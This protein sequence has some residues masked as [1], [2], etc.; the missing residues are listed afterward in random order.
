[1]G[2]DID[3]QHEE[4]GLLEDADSDGER[5]PER[6]DS[7]TDKYGNNELNT[8]RG[9][10][11]IYFQETFLTNEFYD[12]EYYDSG[13]FQLVQELEINRIRKE[14]ERKILKAK[15]A[16]EKKRKELEARKKAKEEAGLEEDI[17]TCI[18][19]SEEKGDV[20]QCNY[21]RNK[22][23]NELKLM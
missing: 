18:R 23:K 15:M 8:V 10:F 16:E 20:I 14:K 22:H 12:I 13:I 21:C 11:K 3:K 7:L 19:I 9:N 17:V 5:Q 6:T 2:Y 4:Y 1:M